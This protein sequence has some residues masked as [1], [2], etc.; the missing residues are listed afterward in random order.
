MPIYEY[1][2][3]A[4]GDRFERIQRFSD[5]DP[6]TCPACGAASPKRRISESAFH[7]KGSG[8]YVTDYARKGADKAGATPSKA[9]EPAASPADAVATPSASP[10]PSPAPAPAG[11][12]PSKP[13]GGTAAA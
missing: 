8:W 9:A 3:S 13:P 10:S 4:C 5:P 7:L 1:D 12:A 2:C 6:E 11:P